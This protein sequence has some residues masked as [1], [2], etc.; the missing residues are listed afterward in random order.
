MLESLQERI[1]WDEI[2]RFTPELYYLYS[3]APQWEIDSPVFTCEADYHGYW[4]RLAQE[5]AQQSKEVIGKWQQ[6]GKEAATAVERA[7]SS[8]SVFDFQS[9]MAE[10]PLPIAK[11]Q[12]HE[13]VALLASNP[14]QPITLPQQEGQTQYVAAL[15][16]LMQMVFD[17]N[18]W[19]LMTAQGHY[20]IR[21]WNAC[22]YKWT[23]DPFQPGPFGQN[24]KIILEKPATEDIFFDPK[25]RFLDWRYMDYVIQRHVMEIGEIMDQYP[26]SGALV[27][28]EADEVISDTSV[29][30]RNNEDYIQSPQPK[31]A[32]GGASRRQKITIFEL[33]IKDSRTEFRPK[34]RKAD[35]PN[36][37][38]RFVLD[39]D[40][41]IIGDWVKRYPGGRM[42]I[43]TGNA[44]LKDLSNPYP[45]DQF[46]FV[47][48]IGEPSIMPYA[49]GDAMAVMTVTR[50]INNMLAAIHRYYQSEV[51]RPM[52]AEAGWSMDPNLAQN[53]PNDPTFIVE[54]APGKALVRPAAMDIPP[55]VLEYV[56][57]LQGLLDLTSGS[58]GVMRG[59]I[60]DGA[61]LSAEALGALQNF[62]SSR[63]AL[64][65]TMFNSA[66]RQLGYQLMWILR[67]TIKQ[68][69]KVT[70][71]LPDGTTQ[72]IDWQSD[73]EVFKKNDPVEVQH[74]RAKEDY[75]VAIKAGTGRPGAR[76]QQQTQSLQLF[77]DNG[78]DRQ[79][80]LEDIQYP[81]RDAVVAR[82]RARELED[83]K[84]K[85]EAKE[86][87][88][89]VNEQIKQNRPGRRN[90]A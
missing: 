1:N 85:G 82:M 34:I 36:Y 62:A 11:S 50:K 39:D 59:Q 51:T 30:S 47:W 57:M 76:E 9:A 29:G 33:W 6:R 48:P 70:V 26:L 21:F 3:T 49:E 10:E 5:L 37:A 7:Q 73:Y 86:L 83:L 28:A 32:R 16:Q 53:V 13:K 88:I 23:V 44:V 46:P 75:L 24:G 68:K 64:S 38:D 87:G 20:D 27:S 45:H 40:G 69:I 12:I 25:A 90:K 42:L 79:A 15:N 55:L 54:H 41:Y 22:C 2:R 67:G 19:P 43:V 89:Q 35:A 61:Q 80:M 77:N 71:T 4:T 74:L 14:P 17:D 31:L 72:P 65:A 84:A 56:G 18:N 58:S 81:N 63:L 8:A 78:I 60:S 52:H 66:I